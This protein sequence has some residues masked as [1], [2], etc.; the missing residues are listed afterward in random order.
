MARWVPRRLSTLRTRLRRCLDL[1][2]E[3]VVLRHQLV[4]LRQTGIRRPCFR[5]SERLFWVFLSH[6]RA[7]WQ[8]GLIIVQPA[9]VLRWRRRGFWAI[10]G[11]GSCGRWRGHPR[12]SSEVRALIVRMSQD[13]FLWRAPRRTAETWIRCLAS[14]G[15]PLY[16]TAACVC[17]QFK[18][19]HID[20]VVRRR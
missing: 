8:R 2:L 17:R 13:N 11:S 19:A 12:I 1:L 5:P 20:G 10:W 14:H 9:T 7:N 15:V 16:A 4:V 6:R 3:F 18:L